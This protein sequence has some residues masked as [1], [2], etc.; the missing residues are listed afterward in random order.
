MRIILGQT[1]QRFAANIKFTPLEHMGNFYCYIL[2]ALLI[3]KILKLTKYD[4]VNSEYC[5][6]SQKYPFNLYKHWK[7]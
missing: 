7:L 2:L 4:S 3:V 6:L 5:K 1:P